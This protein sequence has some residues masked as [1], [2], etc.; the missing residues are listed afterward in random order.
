[1]RDMYP[2]NG[3][4]I[5]HVDMN[6]FYASVEI[7]L[8]PELKGKPLAVAGDP[9]KRHG[10]VVTSSYEARAQGVKTTMTVWEAKRACPELLIKPPDFDRYRK[11]SSVM[12]DLLREYTP[13]VQP[14]SIDEGYL[15]ISEC[16][17]MGTPPQI[18]EHIQKRI[19]EELQLPCSIGVAP[20]KYLAKMASD[21]KKPLGIT[22]LR[23]RDVASKL[24]PLDVGEMHGIGKKTK[25]KLNR[26]GISSIKDLATADR[27]V[28]KKAMGVNGEKMQQR[29]HGVDPRPVD[30][31]AV[32]EFKSIGNSTTLPVDAKD[33]RT[34]SEVLR[35]LAA[36]V[37]KRMYRKDTVAFNIQLLIRYN[38]RKNATRSRQL[39]NPIAEAEEIFQ[40]AHFLWKKHWNGQ[41]IRLLG[42]TAQQLIEKE[43]AFKQLN[44]FTYEDEAQ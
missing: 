20:N 14:V 16:H 24:W 9:K 36:S 23:K 17:H 30:P 25:E 22:V 7:A 6:S 39:N 44:L 27:A 43:E 40:A 1:M 2:K 19:L 10:V 5:L 11:A 18:A 26:I 31:D 29:A 34:V 4:V 32:S 13:L 41:P 21:M 38:D 35:R 8:H 15:D 42:I 3:R 33:E 12:F 37:E 28:L